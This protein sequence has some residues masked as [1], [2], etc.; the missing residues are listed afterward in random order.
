MVIPAVL[1]VPFLL[2]FVLTFLVGATLPI[3]LALCGLLFVAAVLIFFLKQSTGSG[4]ADL[5]IF[6]LAL[7]TGFAA[8]AFGAGAFLGSLI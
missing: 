5:G 1:I 6:I 3:A 8:L 4:A 2:G 7:L